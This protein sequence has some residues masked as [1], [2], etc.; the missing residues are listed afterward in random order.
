[1]VC[2]SGRRRGSKLGFEG[3][4]TWLGESHIHADGVHMGAE[5]NIG[6]RWM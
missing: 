5:K 1:M 4:L 6:F 2:F 3:M